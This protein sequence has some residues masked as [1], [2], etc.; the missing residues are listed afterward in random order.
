MDDIDKIQIWDLDQFLC[1]LKMSIPSGGQM[2]AGAVLFKT[3]DVHSP[4]LT[5]TENG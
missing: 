3:I 2:G 1:S 5:T 4:G